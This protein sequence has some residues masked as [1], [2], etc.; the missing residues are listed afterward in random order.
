MTTLHFKDK[1]REVNVAA[2]VI[3]APFSSSYFNDLSK[4]DSSIRCCVWG[5]WGAE[6]WESLGSVPGDREHMITISIPGI[7]NERCSDDHQSIAHWAKQTGNGVNSDNV[8]CVW[9]CCFHMNATDRWQ[10][11][12]LASWHSLRRWR[13]CQN[14]DMTSYTWKW[15]ADWD[16]PDPR[17]RRPLWLL[18]SC[19]MCNKPPGRTAGERPGSP[20]YST[21]RNGDVKNTKG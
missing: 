10:H 15:S 14:L 1:F 18:G 17:P 6:W 5:G 8:R 11:P 21:N 16:K 19:R 13:C 3:S 12:T 4:R 9:C 20:E 7:R 2:E